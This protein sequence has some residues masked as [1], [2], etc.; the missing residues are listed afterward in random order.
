MNSFF[1]SR[2]FISFVFLLYFSVYASS[3]LYSFTHNSESLRGPGGAESTA[4]CSRDLH[5]YLYDLICHR[6]FPENDTNAPKT[7]SGV[8]LLKKRAVVSN[9]T[10]KL[11]H[12]S[13]VLSHN[14]IPSFFCGDLAASVQFPSSTASPWKFSELYSGLSPP[15]SA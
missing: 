11:I 15:C 14:N 12:L 3:P 13:D 6:L 9:E 5:I 4:A 10:A 7:A 2:K 8:I 1:D